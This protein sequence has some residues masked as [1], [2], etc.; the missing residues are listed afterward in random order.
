MRLSSDDETDMKRQL[1]A[2]FF[3]LHNNYESQ[4]SSQ[5]VPKLHRVG[6]LLLVPWGVAVIPI[7]AVKKQMRSHRFIQIPIHG[8]N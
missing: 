2:L 3:Y 6:V 8:R 1:S 4:L 5:N 7:P